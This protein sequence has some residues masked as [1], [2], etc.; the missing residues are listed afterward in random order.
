MTHIDNI[1]KDSELSRSQIV[2]RSED[3]DDWRSLV[4][5]PEAAYF[6]HG[7]ADK[8]QVNMTKKVRS[9][10]IENLL[11]SQREPMFTQ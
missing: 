2:R 3:R 6:E 7:D 1:K 9:S 8:W 5:K 4:A 10:T 11:K